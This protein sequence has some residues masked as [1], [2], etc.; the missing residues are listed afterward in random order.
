MAVTVK[1]FFETARERAG[2]ELVTGERG[3][4][5]PIHEPA[6]HRPGLAL[7]GFFKH[8]AFRRIQVMGMA[9]HEYLLALGRQERCVCLR[10]LFQRRIPCLVV[11][12][13]RKVWPEIL[14]LASEFR[15]PILRTPLITGPF[16][17]L[18]T[19]I[20]EHFMAPRATVQG[21]EG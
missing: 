1:D 5:R 16:I 9:E 3:L 18:A 20:M 4:A 13:G 19:M 21:T 14:D 11:T 2:L 7:A 12:R 6:I 8:F 10:R 17:N 15:I